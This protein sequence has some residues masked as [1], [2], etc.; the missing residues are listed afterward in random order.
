[1]SPSAAAQP[2]RRNV[3]V[4]QLE[5][6]LDEVSSA[7]SPR[8]PTARGASHD[9]KRHER[10]LR[11]KGD[12]VSCEN[13]KGR[14]RTRALDASTTEAARGGLISHHTIVTKRK[15]TCQSHN[16]PGE[17]LQRGPAVQLS[18]EVALLQHRPSAASSLS[19]SMVSC[20]LMTDQH[21]F[22][23]VRILFT[24]HD[25]LHAHEYVP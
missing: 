21:H 22:L 14:R 12:D 19:N 7:A 25:F 5:D 23:S 13:D 16:D 8:T 1:M 4:Q 6:V 9:G 3:T 10:Q 15:N 17:K 11:I 2:K 20:C 18:P 24:C